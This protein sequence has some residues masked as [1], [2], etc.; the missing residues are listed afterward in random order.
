MAKSMRSKREKRL[1]AIRREIVEP[2]Y[3]KKD[4]AKLAAQE[5]ALAAPKLPVRA[6]DTGSMQVEEQ[7]TAPNSTTTNLNPMEV[8]MADS[9]QSKGK[10]SL[11]AVGGIGKKS[12]NKFKLAKKKR[13]ACGKGKIRGKHNL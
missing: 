12:K 6:P 8:G 1:R 10:A 7:V 3:Q 11:K 9:D 5:A 2:F 4:E 13:R